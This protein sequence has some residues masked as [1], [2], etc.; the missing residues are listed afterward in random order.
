MPHS[1]LRWR[2]LP[3]ALLLAAGFAG[4][5][6]SPAAEPASGG[7]GEIC[8]A[9]FH[10]EEPKDGLPAPSTLQPNMS[11]TTWAPA[12]DSTFTFRVNK[13]EVKVRNREMGRITGLPVDRKVLVEIRLDGKPFE[14]F[15]LHL[16]EEPGNRVCLWL[17]SGYWR[18]VDMGWDAGKG[19]KCG[20]AGG[21]T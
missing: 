3:F 16:G 17:Y 5:A 14:A 1:T 19:C 7:P 9:P 6:P 10:R 21:A 4:A 18:W 13:Q 11:R 15:R 8:I 12:W 20:E 2:R